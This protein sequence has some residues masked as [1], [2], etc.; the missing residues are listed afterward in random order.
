MEDERQAT[1]ERLIAGLDD[2]M[3]A[4]FPNWSDKWVQVSEVKQL[5]ATEFLVERRGAGSQPENEGNS[6]GSHS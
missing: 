1:Y 6:D 3:V 4:R 5:L 2:L